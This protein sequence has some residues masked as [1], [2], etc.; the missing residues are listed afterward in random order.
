MHLDRQLELLE[1]Y[2]RR[3]GSSAGLPEVTSLAV[4]IKRRRA[5]VAAAEIEVARLLDKIERLGEEVERMEAASELEVSRAILS[6]QQRHG[7]VWSPTPVVGFRAWSVDVDGLRGVRAMWTSPTFE[8]TCEGLFGPRIDREVPHTDGTCGPPPCGIYATHEVEALLASG[9]TD[10]LP[11]L[12]VGMVALSGKVVEHEHGYRA[13]IAT[14]SSILGFCS[15]RAY[16]TAD[17]GAIAELIA[18]PRAT[19]GRLG[20]PIDRD[21]KDIAIERYGRRHHGHRKAEA[22]DHRRA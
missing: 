5:Q 7:E 18:A 17:P 16:F 6:I 4:G 2:R 9:L 21:R 1:T 13:Q 11:D 15:D 19:I 10:N 12:A 8:A 20:I 22:S 14:I 3:Y